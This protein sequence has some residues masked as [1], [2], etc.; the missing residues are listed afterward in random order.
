MAIARST[1]RL[2]WVETE[3]A[4]WTNFV[5]MPLDASPNLQ[6]FMGRVAGRAG[7]QAAL[8]AEGLMK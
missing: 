2:A 7:V 1:K 3:L 5:G 6:A 8:K 4:D